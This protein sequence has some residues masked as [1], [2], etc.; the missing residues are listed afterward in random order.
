MMKWSLPLLIGA[1]SVI[2]LFIPSEPLPVKVIFKLIPMFLIIVFAFRQLSSKPT[3]ALRFI[4]LGLFFCT[5]GD[6]FIAVSFIAGLGAFLV[7]H[8]FYLCGFIYLSRMNKW[9]LAA[10]IPIALYSF[11]IGRQLISALRTDGDIGLVIPVIAYMLVISIMALSAI[12]TGNKWAIAGSILFVLSDSILS[13]NMFVS[14]IP[15]SA[16]FIMT[17]YY[18]AQFLIASSLS[19][20]QQIKET[21][22]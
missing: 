3:P 22:V 11:L 18:S 21:I 4:L 8:L 16:V 12:L 20:L 14:E 17:T 19:S 6:A 15:F 1:M 5:L 13:W 9:R 10:A 7:G 2:Y